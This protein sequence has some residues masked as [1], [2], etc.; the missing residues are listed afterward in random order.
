[1]TTNYNNG[2]IYK[3]VDNLS[4]MLY[5]GSTCNTLEQRLKAHISDYKSF[6]LGGKNNITSFKILENNDFKIELIE[7][8]PC[9]NK[10]Q[11]EKREGYFI[12]LYRQ[13]ELN[14]VN[15]CIVGQDPYGYINCKCGNRYI[16]K[17]EAK[18]KRS[19]PHRKGLE[20]INTPKIIIPGDNNNITINIYCNSKEDLNKLNIV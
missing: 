9:E 20:L 11:L 6:K 12:K 3:I 10:S 15:R 19:Y 1:M 14:I 8:Y 2:K 4:D 18:H 7:N 13:Q 16:H 17:K 5:V